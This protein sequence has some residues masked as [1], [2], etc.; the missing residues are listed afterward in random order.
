MSAVVYPGVQHELAM[1]R[2]SS[3]RRTSSSEE[4]TTE[5]ITVPTSI[6]LGIGGLAY[7]VDI[8]GD[9]AYVACCNYVAMINMKNPQKPKLVT[10]AYVPGTA[11]YLC[12]RGQNVFVACQTGGVAVLNA[13]M[14][15]TDLTLV[16]RLKMPNTKY[17]AMNVQ[18]FQKSPIVVVACG[19]AGICIYDTNTYARLS[20]INLGYKAKAV[21]I[22]DERYVLVAC[23]D[24]MLIA[25]DLQDPAKPIVVACKRLFSGD[26]HAI[27]TDLDP[28]EGLSAQFAF[29][30][31][32][33]KGV[34]IVDVSDVTNMEGMG[35]VRSAYGTIFDVR[36][37]PEKQLL[38]CACQIGGIAV[39]SIAALHQ[40]LSSRRHSVSH[41]SSS[42]QQVQLQLVGQFNGF[43]GI[44]HGVCG[45]G[46]EALIS[47]QTGGV[48]V[49]K[50][51]N[52]SSWPS[53]ER[54][55]FGD[56]CKK[57]NTSS[58]I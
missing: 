9:I 56:S 16:A 49:V 55:G 13:N 12:A 24:G 10:K 23:Q 42:Q 31:C 32:G 18:L 57:P 47:C 5:S 19:E 35:Q 51:D 21:S 28:V 17:S 26:A 50:L 37:V 6:G 3:M 39:F 11:L 20:S 52:M 1:I 36:V 22:K 25:V 41:S 40:N 33:N 48:Q 43:I 34:S 8:S 29:V 4:T 44:C 2:E 14:N 15:N 45:H 58:N 7:G 46:D 27:T 53:P 30:A 54:A 38:L